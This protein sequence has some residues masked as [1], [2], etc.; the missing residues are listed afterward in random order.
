MTLAA[1]A[2]AK[3]L[4]LKFKVCETTATPSAAQTTTTL[5][6][7]VTLTVGSPRKD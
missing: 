2:A 4:D 1:R 7:S 3:I 6:S 5:E